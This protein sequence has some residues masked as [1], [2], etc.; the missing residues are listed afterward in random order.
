MHEGLTEVVRGSLTGSVIGNL[1]L[2]L[3]F[4]LLAGP[5]GD[6]DRWSSF[7]SFGAIAVAILLFLVPAIPSWE[8]DPDRELIA[9]LSVPVSI[10]LLVFYVVA[11][12][13]S[14]RRHRSLHIATDEEIEGWSFRLSLSSRRPRPSSPRSSPRS[15]SARS[16]CS[17]K[18]SA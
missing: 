9:Q 17:R 2:V 12:Y 3:G 15:S 4:S 7:M 11:T 5:R 14:L 10:I 6:I 16:R 8:G 18:R 1:L 13:V